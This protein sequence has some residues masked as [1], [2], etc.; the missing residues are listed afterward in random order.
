MC[1]H[2]VLIYHR[3]DTLARLKVDLNINNIVVIY[4]G[5]NTL[6]KLKVELNVY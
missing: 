2:E 5:K 4:H 1:N 3:K 6:A